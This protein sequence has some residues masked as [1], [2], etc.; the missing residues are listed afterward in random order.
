MKKA[1]LIGVAA[2]ALLA[3]PPVRSKI[4]FYASQFSNAMKENEEYITRTLLAPSSGKL[5]RPTY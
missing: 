2:A 3:L 4:S 5:V 1:I